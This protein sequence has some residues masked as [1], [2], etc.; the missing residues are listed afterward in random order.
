MKKV[1]ATAMAICMT[2]VCASC[3]CDNNRTENG[4][5]PLT[6]Y[7]ES[8]PFYAPDGT[9]VYTYEYDYLKT[10]EEKY[11][12]LAQ[13]LADMAQECEKNMMGE[14]EENSESYV[15]EIVEAAI[16]QYTSSPESFSE[17][18]EYYDKVNYIVARADESVVSIAITAHGYWGGAHP[19]SAKSGMNINPKTGEELSLDMVSEDCEALE[20]MIYDVLTESYDEEEFFP[21]MKELLEQCIA[22]D[23]LEWVLED[24]AIVFFF[25]PYVI[26][27]YSMGIIEARIDFENHGELFK[28]EYVN[29]AE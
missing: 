5:V 16:A 23:S 7:T 17:D 27:P 13:K 1:L 3:G 9:K 19:N 18:E 24:D 6:K 12:L 14:S 15:A 10:D 22:N 21:N 2:M 29:K 20:K 11:P 28:A 8:K 25:S 4:S 26:A